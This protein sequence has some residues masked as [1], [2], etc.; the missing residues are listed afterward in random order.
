[1]PISPM[2]PSISTNAYED[3]SIVDGSHPDIQTPSQ[4]YGYA[5]QF[6]SVNQQSLS[7]LDPSLQQPSPFSASF[8]TG[9]IDD[10]FTVSEDNSF[11]SE[12]VECPI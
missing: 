10:T 11:W 2:S 6:H 3:G 9:S 7:H 5:A 4:F 8:T 12:D 1:M